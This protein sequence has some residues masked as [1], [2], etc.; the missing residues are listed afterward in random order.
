MTKYYAIHAF[1]S[2]YGG[3]HGIYN[4]SIQPCNSDEDAANILDLMAH[5]VYYDYCEDEYP[6][7]E[8]E[9]DGEYFFIGEDLS[10]E[11]LDMA[12]EMAY[13]DFG[14]LREMVVAGKAPWQN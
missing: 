5:E 7:E 14:G 2:L 1:E 9:P 3:Y 13:N 4:I 11:H 12:D 10:K 6:E 8:L